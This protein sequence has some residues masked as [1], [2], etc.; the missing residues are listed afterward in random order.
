MKWLWRIAP[1]ALV[2]CVMA[3]TAAERPASPQADRDATVAGDTAFA[4]DLYGQLKS[5]DGNLFVSPYSISSALA[6]TYAGA[7]GNTADEMAKT[8]HFTMSQDKLHPAYADRL[9][10][11]NGDTKRAYLLSV[12]NALWGQQG[13]PWRDEFLALAKAN[14]DAGLNPIDFR[15]T[16]AA[17]KTINEWVEKQTQEKIKELLQPGVLTPATRMVLTNAI[18]FKGNWVKQFDPKRTYTGQFWADAK[19]PV[20]APL[21][22]QSGEFNFFVSPELKMVELPYSGKDLSMLVLLPA[23]RDGVAELEK[24]LT[25]AKLADWSKQLKPTRELPV[26]LPKFKFTSEFKLNDQLIA[27][28]MKDA[29]DI[30]K[31]DFSGMT[32]SAEGLYID[33]VIHKAFVDVNEEGTEAAAATAVV[34]AP[35]GIRQTPTFVADHPFVFVIRDNKSGAVL[36]MGRV[37]DPTK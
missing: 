22:N 18:Y 21:M 4:F 29:F 14:Y 33:A 35:R 36:F 27:L 15:A 12:A 23:K 28:G 25:P 1:I 31:A 8:M 5:K 11:L 2:G 13:Y 6:M 30:H 32:A 16:E 9:K 19:T 24:Q 26:T 7:K 34:M 37:T 3:L 10:A 17:R 20:K